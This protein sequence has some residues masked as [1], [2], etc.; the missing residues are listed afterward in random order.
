MLLLIRH[1]NRTFP[2]F[3]FYDTAFGEKSQAFVGKKQYN[4]RKSAQKT[5]PWLNM[6]CKKT[7]KA[8]RCAPFLCP[9]RVQNAF[10]V[11]PPCAAAQRS[12][13]YSARV[14]SRSSAQNACLCT[15]TC[16]GDILQTPPHRTHISKVSP[17]YCPLRQAPGCIP[18]GT[19]LRYARM[20]IFYRLFTPIISRK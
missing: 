6:F 14:S 20:H 4:M 15:R 8:C 11:C 7:P 1:S 16:R 12:L 19:L 5:N 9:K 13:V 17:R 10:T 18:G 3:R 2:E